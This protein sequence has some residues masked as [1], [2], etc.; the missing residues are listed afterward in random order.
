MAACAGR[1]RSVEYGPVDVVDRAEHM[2]D[3]AD[4]STRE[5]RCGDRPTVQIL[6]LAGISAIQPVAK[7]PEL[8]EGGRRRDAAEIEAERAAA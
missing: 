5:R 1:R 6:H 7:E 2:T 8:R 4:G 3:R